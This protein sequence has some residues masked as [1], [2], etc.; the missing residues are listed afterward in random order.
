M[1]SDIF[2]QAKQAAA[3]AGL[4]LEGIDT[5]DQWAEYIKIWREKINAPDWLRDFEVIELIGKSEREIEQYYQNHSPYFS[6]G[7]REAK[8]PEKI[9]NIRI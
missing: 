3:K 8:K 6:G 5:A 9:G 4:I 7:E 2:Q 1:M